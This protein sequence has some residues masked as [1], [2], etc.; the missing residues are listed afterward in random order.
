MCDTVT[1]LTYWY[2]IPY[3]VHHT[4]IN[5]RCLVYDTI[6]SYSTGAFVE[7]AGFYAANDVYQVRHLLLHVHVARINSRFHV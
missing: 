4:T 2:V 5:N 7:R 3:L 6:T 1:Q